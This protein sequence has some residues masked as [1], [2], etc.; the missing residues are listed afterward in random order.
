MNEADVVVDLFDVYGYRIHDDVALAFHNT[1]VVSFS[2]TYHAQL[3]GQPE[4]I[5]GVPSAPTGHAFVD[6]KPTKYQQRRFSISVVGPSLG[7]NEIKGDF[8]VDPAKANPKLIS[9]ADLANKSYEPDLLG[10]L[11]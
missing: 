8:F 4:V 7:N 10:L 6:V 1:D 2:K 3:R 9:H 11:L 5:H